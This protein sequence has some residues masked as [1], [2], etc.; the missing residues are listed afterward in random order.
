MLLRLAISCSAILPTLFSLA[1]VSQAQAQSTETLP[2]YTLQVASFPDT[3]LAEKFVAKLQRAGEKPGWGTVELPKRGRW[4]RV[5]IGSFKTIET[6]RLYGKELVERRIIE[7][8]LVKTTDDVETLSRP[9]TAMS[10]NLQPAS[11][12]A[13]LIRASIVSQSSEPAIERIK[14][15]SSASTFSSSLRPAAGSDSA[16]KAINPERLLVAG[17]LM[18][19]YSAPLPA[20]AKTKLAL[21]PPISMNSLPRPDPARMAFNLIVGESA[22]KGGLWVTG[23]INEALNRLR[24]I[25]GRENAELISLDESGRLRLNRMLLIRAANASEANPLEAPLL[26]A[27]YINSNEGLL[28]LVQ[29][30]QGRYRYCLRIGRQAPTA[31]GMIEVTGSANLDNNFDSRIN[32]YRRDGKKLGRELPPE[33]F[34][35]LIAINPIALWFNLRMKSI[36][37]VGHITFH[38][39]AEAHAKLELRLDYLERDAQPG[40]H[41]IAIS[42]E[43]R[44]KSQRPFS[45]VIVTLGANRVLR[46]E[47]EIRQFYSENGDLGG[48]KR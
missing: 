42:R 11:D 19:A 18:P 1:L 32:P 40:A 34:D 43:E 38:E 7:E 25:V 10:L 39:L 29:L 16:I 35:S 3:S 24:W 21:A 41:N 36:V 48:S 33:N 4:T 9:R 23:D 47:E 28:L 8:Y 22:Q 20:A 5:F 44:L 27:N 14:P 17:S 26:V 30:S 46:S 37:P 13:R 45:D 12:S 6:A 2:C 15:V 31:G